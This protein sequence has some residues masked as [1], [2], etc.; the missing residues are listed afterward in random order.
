M[1]LRQSLSLTRTHTLSYVPVRF[2]DRIVRD[3]PVPLPGDGSQIVS[4]THAADVACMVAAALDTPVAKEQVYNCGTDAEVTYSELVAMV[5]ALCGKEVLLFFE[6]Q[7]T[8]A[9][10]KGQGDTES[11][12]ERI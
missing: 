11:V 5:A 1:T 6:S 7:E 8:A 10:W 2:F 12:L 4:L 9:G 3:L